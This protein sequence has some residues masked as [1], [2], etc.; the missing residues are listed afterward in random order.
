[1][2]KWNSIEIIREGSE[3]NSWNALEVFN[4][5]KNKK[6]KEISEI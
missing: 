1:M 3:A 5:F 6:E 2:I 4:E